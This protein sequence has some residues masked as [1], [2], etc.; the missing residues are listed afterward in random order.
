MGLLK[1]STDNPDLGPML[2]ELEQDTRTRII[3][4]LEAIGLETIAYLRSKTK[5]MRP[6][7]RAGRK[8]RPAHPGHWADVTGQLVNSYSYRVEN[9]PHGVSLVFENSAEYAAALEAKEG[10]FVLSGVADP[11][12]PVDQALRRIVPIIAPDWTII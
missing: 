8:P 1:F 4:V 3:M 2:L 6:P 11:G 10:Y 5:E 12:G 7:V 9:L